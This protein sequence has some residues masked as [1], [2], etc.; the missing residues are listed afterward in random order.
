MK[1]KLLEEI[2]ELK[3]SLRSEMHKQL[4]Y[5]DPF[6]ALDIQ[7][8]YPFRP[9]SPDEFNVINTLVDNMLEF[10]REESTQSGI[11]TSPVFLHIFEHYRG[12]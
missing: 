11:E 7:S 2:L 1:I 10:H 3:H 12:V 5:N 9:Y 4:R 8:T 6:E